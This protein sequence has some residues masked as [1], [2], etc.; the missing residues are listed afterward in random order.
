LANGKAIHG[1]EEVYW[2][3][4]A[5]VRK[6][7]K[8]GSTAKILLGEGG[9]KERGGG[10]IVTFLTWEEKQS[11]RHDRK[12]GFCT[13]LKTHNGVEEKGE[14]K[15]EHLPTSSREEERR[16]YIKKETIR[17]I[18]KLKVNGRYFCK[19]MFN[20]G[21]GGKKETLRTPSKNKGKRSKIREYVFL[22]G[23]RRR[24]IKEVR[25]AARQ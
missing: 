11:K 25:V 18:T 7:R 2:V 9:R 6:K 12:K 19:A 22:R 23:G 8:E 17:S 3:G 5:R 14:R 24:G 10:E 1:G 13:G 21:G 16:G 20:N 4:C 15:D